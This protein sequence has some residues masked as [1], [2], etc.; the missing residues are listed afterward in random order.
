MLQ[1]IV[2]H[3]PEAERGV[4]GAVL[5]DPDCLPLVRAVIAPPAFYFAHHQSLFRVICDLDERQKSIDLVTLHEELKTQKQLEEI[6]GVPYL[7]ELWESVPTGANAEYHAKL[8]QDAALVRGL[9][10]TTN[11]ILRDAYDRCD[12]APDMIAAAQAKLA[13]LGVLAAGAKS[14][15]RMIGEVM[16]EVL[17][18]VDDRIAAGHDITGLPTG[19]LG[20]DR[21]L[22]GLK[23]GQLVIVGA[24]PSAGKTA[25]GINVAA[26][27][28][29]NSFPTM[30]F[31]LEMSAVDI[32]G[33]VLSMESGVPM[34]RFTQGTSLDDADSK[35]L[36]DSTELRV[37]H[38][39]I[40][41]DDT[42]GITVLQLNSVVRLAMRR[43]R[44]GLVVV[45][46]L[47]LIEPTEKRRGDNRAQEVSDITKRL[48]RLAREWNIPV[49]CMCQLNRESESAGRRPRLS[50]L[51]E[52]GSIEQDADV[53]MLLHR[54]PNQS[55]HAEHWSVD[56]DIAKQRNGPV[57]IVPLNFRRGVMRFEEKSNW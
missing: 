42:P 28:S 25:F 12:A 5:R 57:G 32:A 56:C 31:S 19:F 46:Y 8:V 13:D 14:N 34:S 40:L 1:R 45:D 27:V 9:I 43:H 33:R 16:R 47:Q 21:M 39:G 26:H 10:H 52:S 24:R 53:V 48:K 54:E 4:L 50:D 3:S 36:I 11:E 55:E 41:V 29:L 7:T 51:R 37:Q 22:G 38:G 17:R 44:I 49:L 30:V 18:N 35:R 2:P 23:A 15:V 6:G 20:I